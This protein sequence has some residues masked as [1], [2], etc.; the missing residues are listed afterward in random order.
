MS[1]YFFLPEDYN[2]GSWQ[3]LPRYNC[4]REEKKKKKAKEGKMNSWTNL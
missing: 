2:D 3:S 4:E 1:I